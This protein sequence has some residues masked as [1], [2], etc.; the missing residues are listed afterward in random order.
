M[1]DFHQ[2]GCLVL[3]E[4]IR[5]FDTKYG[6]SFTRFFELLLV[7]KFLTLLKK[8]NKP[9]AILSEEIINTIHVEESK[10]IYMTKKHIEK[11]KKNLTEIEFQIFCE[12]YVNNEKIAS[13]CQKLG[14]QEKKVY[15]ALY[16]IKI[17]LRCF[18]ELS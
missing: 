14:L 5:K 3:L 12:H 10:P 16:R 9:M 1:E 17:K 6:K 15:N 7:R 13:I 2:E 18:N 11:A 4:A 8:N